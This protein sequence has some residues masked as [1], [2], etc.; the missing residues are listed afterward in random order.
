MGAL[1]PVVAFVLGCA[2]LVSGITGISHVRRSKAKRRNMIVLSL[3]ELL[4][5][6]AGSVMRRE[7][8]IETVSRALIVLGSVIGLVAYLKL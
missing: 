3:D 6:G 7:A 5:Y 8:R 2:M 4:G 1:F